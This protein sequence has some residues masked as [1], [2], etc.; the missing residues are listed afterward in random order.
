MITRR[1]EQR[2]KH[3]ETNRMNKYFSS[4]MYLDLNVRITDLLYLSILHRHPSPMR[5]N[6]N[7]RD[8]FFLVKLCF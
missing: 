7:T 4:D 2:R 3:T 1:T 6:T 5:E 8:V